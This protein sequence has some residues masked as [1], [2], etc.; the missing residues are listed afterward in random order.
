[1]IQQVNKKVKQRHQKHSR[2]DCNGE[3]TFQHFDQNDSHADKTTFH[4]GGIDQFVDTI[5][6]SRS[7]DEMFG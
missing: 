1:M 6:S 3:K 4:F 7:A 5:T 2:V